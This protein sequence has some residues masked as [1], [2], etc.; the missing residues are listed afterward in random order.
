MALLAFLPES[1][2]LCSGPPGAFS[3]KRLVERTRLMA[4]ITIPICSPIAQY[5]ALQQ[6]ID[7]VVRQVLASGL[8]L[9]GPWTRRFADQFAEWCGVRYCVP[10]AN[11]TDALEM[12]LRALR[13]GPGDEVITTANA[14]G[15]ATAACHVIGAT[16]VWVDVCPTTLGLDPDRLAA[17]V[18]DRTRVVVVTHLFGI[19]GALDKIRG[20]LARMGRGDVGI[21]EDC[22]HAHGA[23]VD[24]KRAGASGDI[25]IFSFYPT[26]NLG[27]LG[28]AGA[29]VTDRAELADRVAQL[30][31]YGWK[32]KYHS[33]LAG[34]RNSRMD[35]LQAAVL[36]VKLPHVEGWNARRRQ[37]L[38]SY[39]AGIRPP[40]FVVGATEDANVAH[41]AIVRSR[42]RDAI[43][44]AMAR[45]GIATE[46]HFPVLDSDQVSQRGLPGRRL[47]LPVS[48]RAREEILTLPCY[49]E[50]ID[51]QVDA[52]IATVNDATSQQ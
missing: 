31:Q 33:E 7:D 14:G 49:P 37:I 30:R 15:Y 26:K 5:R 18:T 43:R 34:G 21:L 42:H 8:W 10:L 12:A 2:S 36:C 4:E 3:L 9:N 46:I 20:A 6:Q 1:R 25:A 11:G 45:A 47:P 39:A 32:E 51:S 17:A 27:A 40:N 44:R 28:D 48:E 35:E 38:R 22:S 29:V 41:M 19:P 24:G 23:A 16:P 13:V 52:V 50:M